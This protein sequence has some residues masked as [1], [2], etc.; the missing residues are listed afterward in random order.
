MT[1]LEKARY[2]WDESM[3]GVQVDEVIMGNVLQA[4][5]GQN[6]ARQAMIHAGVPKETNAFTVSKVCASGMKAI[7]LGLSP[8]WWETRTSW[9]QGEWRT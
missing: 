2:K 6:P 4:G 8:S 9:W 1:E 3:Q 5:Q 7:A